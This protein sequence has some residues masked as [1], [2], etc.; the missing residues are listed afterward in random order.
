MLKYFSRFFSKGH[1]RSL[2]VKKNIFYSLIIKGG[3]IVISLALLP[4]T[5]KFVNDTQYGLWL[6]L[7]SIIGWFNFFD[8]GLG[9]GLRTKLTEAISK[10]DFKQGKIYVST[11]YAMLAIL[12]ASL[13]VLFFGLQFF[14][15]WSKILNA[16]A[17]YSNEL[18]TVACIIFL[19]FTFQFVL[20]LIVVVAAANQNTVIGSLI[21]FIGNLITII[22]IFFLTKF[23]VTGTLLQLAIPVCIIPLL[24][25]LIFTKALYSKRFKAISPSLRFVDFS[26]LRDLMG[27]GV[28]FFII[29]MG[30]ILYY[31]I[32]NMVITQV[33]GPKQVTPYAIAYKYFGVITMIS[34][35]VMTPLWTAFAEA[36]AKK[37]YDWIKKTVRNMQLLCLALV[38]LGIIMVLASP[39]VYR[40]WVG[41]AIEIPIALSAVLAFY[42]IWNTF[43]TVFIYYL[44]GVGVL[45]LQVY[46][47]LIS[48]LLNVPLAIFLARRFGITGVT[49]ST[50]ILCVICGI[51]EI[52]QYRR[53]ISQKAT[54][55]WTR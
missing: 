17:A 38:P 41:K 3:S 15:D 54:G 51:I 16:P 23:Y 47:V 42:T 10:E 50:T 13:L 20:N 55:I 39:Y 24:V 6:T 7:S 22:A 18:S 21:N 52:T 8:I 49:L 14:V 4:L 46:L 48:G 34:A 28:K 33:L 30:L 25:L 1:S 31:N 36:H 35:I 44:N 53:L 43:R 19:S 45:R 37:D 2:I 9:N 29:Q 5:I 11:T 27:L 12:S 32:D 26:C 40:L